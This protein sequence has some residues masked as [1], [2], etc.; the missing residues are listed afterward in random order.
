MASP[1]KTIWKGDVQATSM[2]TGAQVSSVKSKAVAEATTKRKLADLAHIN[3]EDISLIQAT[4][5]GR[6]VS[7]RKLNHCGQLFCLCARRILKV[8]TN[9][10]II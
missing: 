10:V 5:G 6:K 7:P 8:S 4:K 9:I 3:E 2:S 1:E